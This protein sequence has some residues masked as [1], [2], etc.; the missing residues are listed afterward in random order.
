MNIPLPSAQEQLASRKRLN[1]L[2]R[3]TPAQKI[4]QER[5]IIHSDWFSTRCPWP[6]YSDENTR[7]E[8]VRQSEFVG[9]QSLRRIGI[10]VAQHFEITEGDIYTARKTANIVIPRQVAMYLA[11]VLTLRSYPE[12]GRF[13]KRDHTTVL[14]GVHKIEKLISESE[15]FALEVR[16]LRAKLEEG[17]S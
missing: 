14:Y 7:V 6:C 3:T 8:L 17:I 13:F 4:T 16:L 10:I 12:I 1:A 11:K 2:F 15:A 9:R 5:V